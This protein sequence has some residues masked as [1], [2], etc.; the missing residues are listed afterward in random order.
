MI[1]LYFILADLYLFF[2][3]Y[4]A[5]MGM[6][7]AHKEGKLNPVLWGL[8]T[9]FVA[10]SLVIDVIHNLTLFIFI[11]GELPSELTVTERLKRHYKKPTVRGKIATWLGDTLLNPFDYSGDHLD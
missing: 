8:C 1:W 2:I 4:V 6:I 3:M 10:I 5:S 7:R 9:P 11:F